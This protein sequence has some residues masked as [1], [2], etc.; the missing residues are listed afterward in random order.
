[1]F[2]MRRLGELMILQTDLFPVTLKHAFATKRLTNA[3]PGSKKC[4]DFRIN[5]IDETSGWWLKLRDALFTKKHVLVVHNQV[6]GGNV[7]VLDPSIQ[8][9]SVETG[10]FRYHIAGDGDA[11]IKPFMRQPIFIGITT[12]DCLPCIVYEPDSHTVAV[13]HAGWRGLASDI[14]GNAVRAFKSELGIDSK[15][16]FWAIGPSIDPKNYEVGTEVIAGLEASGYA[17]TDWIDNP[18]MAPCWT[19]SRRRDHFLLNLAECIRYRLIS[20]RV[21]ESQIDICKLSTFDNPNLFYSYRRDREIVGL[22]ACVVG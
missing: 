1:M 2:H 11:I 9:D 18:D 14:H 15:D 10:G 12:A 21:P 6:H 19:R 22:Q 4:A 20:M 8:L 7:R 16:L 17:E 3:P 5:S 13:V